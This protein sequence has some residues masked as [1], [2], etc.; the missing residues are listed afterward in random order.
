VALAL[1]L[2]AVSTV[3]VWVSLSAY[4]LDF[5]PRQEMARNEST[6]LLYSATAWTFGPFAGVL[7]L[8]WWRRRRSS[9]LGA[10]P[11]SW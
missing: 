7:L 1:P 2:H 3:T 10:S 9:W 6:R 4:V 11:F 8:D 5:V